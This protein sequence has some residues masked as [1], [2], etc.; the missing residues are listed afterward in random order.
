MPCLVISDP[1]LV[2]SVNGWHQFPMLGSVLRALIWCKALNS[3]TSPSTC[4]TLHIKNFNLQ[5]WGKSFHIKKFIT[6]V[7]RIYR[8]YVCSNSKICPHLKSR[9]RSNYSYIYRID[10]NTTAL[11]IR[12]AVAN[13]FNKSPLFGANTWL[14]R[15]NLTEIWIQRHTKTIYG[16]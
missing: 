3:L 14:E 15:S 1:S 12:A 5:K 10:A 13:F 2:Q 16:N 7:R 8:Q 9:W 6:D 4:S 11:L